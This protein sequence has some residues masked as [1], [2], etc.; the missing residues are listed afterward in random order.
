M[1]CQVLNASLP[2]YCQLK[3]RDGF[4]TSPKIQPWE[5][6]IVIYNIFST[7]YNPL[8]NMMSGEHMRLIFLYDLM[9][10]NNALETEENISMAIWMLILTKK[11]QNNC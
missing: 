9:L 5:Q 7:I 3:T 6:F 10:V 11:L 8:M 2:N 1:K 4:P